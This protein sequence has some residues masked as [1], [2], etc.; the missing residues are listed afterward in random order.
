MTDY[1]E[2]FMHLLKSNNIDIEKF[3]KNFFL[4]VIDLRCENLSLEKNQYF[5]Y[6]I[7]YNNEIFYFKDTLYNHYSLFFRNPLIFSLLEQYILSL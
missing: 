2:S 6:I 7:K 4:K 1:P 5:D 3:D